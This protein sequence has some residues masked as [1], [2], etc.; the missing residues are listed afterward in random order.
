MKLKTIICI[1]LSLHSLHGLAIKYSDDQIKSMIDDS[2]ESLKTNNILNP[3][4]CPHDFKTAS[5]YNHL[6]HQA[7]ERNFYSATARDELLNKKFYP[8]IHINH[9]DS[10]K[11]SY[12]CS[13]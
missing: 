1:A 3:R 4:R 10:F 5:F 6:I 7:Y 8:M 11:I 2:L 13:F 12:L 9:D